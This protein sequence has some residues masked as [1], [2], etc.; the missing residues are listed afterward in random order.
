[1]RGRGKREVGDRGRGERKGR[2]GEE[3]VK[4]D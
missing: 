3:I 4:W 2:E 1:M